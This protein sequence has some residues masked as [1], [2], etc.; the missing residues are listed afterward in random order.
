MPRQR[1]SAISPAAEPFHVGIVPYRLKSGRLARQN[2]RRRPSGA[3][4]ER[5][6]RVQLPRRGE[7]L[8]GE[9]TGKRTDGNRYLVDVEMRA[10]NQRE[11]TIGCGEATLALPGR[12]HG[13]VLL[14]T[15]TADIARSPI[16][17]M[18]RHAELLRAGS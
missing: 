8:R 1:Q 7:R 18:S 13:R 6:P 14:S 4:A 3:P 17:V 5:D 15:S 2:G 11:E 12:Q 9:V 16:T 10:V